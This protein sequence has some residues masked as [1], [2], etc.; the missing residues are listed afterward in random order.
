[1]EFEYIS[2]EARQQ[3][4]RAL[5]RSVAQGDTRREAREACLREELQLRLNGWRLKDGREGQR[6]ARD[7]LQGPHDRD[8]QQGMPANVEEILIETDGRETKALL[9]GQS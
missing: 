5:A 7:L 4:Q 3:E 9:P 8:R 2:A 6:A 1:M